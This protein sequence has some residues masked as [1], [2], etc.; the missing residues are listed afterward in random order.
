MAVVQCYLVGQ[1]LWQL[2]TSPL[3]ARK[4]QHNSVIAFE[5][6]LWIYL[7]GTIMRII[8]ILALTPSEA[9]LQ[10]SLFPLAA[11]LAILLIPIGTCVLIWHEL[12]V[13]DEAI[14]IAT[15]TDI[16]SGLPN[17]ATF[18]R[19]LERHLASA[20][21]QQASIVGLLR[22]KPL[23]RNLE[24]YE[25]AAAYRSL[26]ARIERFLARSD[27]LART[28]DDEFGV[29]FH[30]GSD[31]ARA[32]T[33]LKYLLVDLQCSPVAGER[34]HHDMNAAAVLLS[35]GHSTG[36]AGEVVKILR[37]GLEGTPLGEVRILT[38]PSRGAARSAA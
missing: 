24:P 4:P 3:G 37:E 2:H 33:V 19:S 1:L 10:G 7:G 21:T 23:V 36:T 12:E 26:G 38:L 11:L 34:D 25:E 28:G 32:T 22:L 20:P 18:L 13:R 5:V 30:E 17:R 35:C 15:S 9:S 29:L 16:S 6:L 27:M 8:A 31:I 14:R